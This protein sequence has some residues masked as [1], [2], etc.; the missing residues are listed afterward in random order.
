MSYAEEMSLQEFLEEIAKRTAHLSADAFG[1]ARVRI[2]PNTKPNVFTEAGVQID[3]YSPETE[4]E[5]AWRLDQEVL[6]EIEERA[7][8][9]RL[10]R[11]FGELS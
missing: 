8:L 9:K 2:I 7:E 1:S 11:K 5:R 3:G 4:G 6:Y 10:K